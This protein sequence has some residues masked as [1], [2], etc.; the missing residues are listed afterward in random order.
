MN[1]KDLDLPVAIAHRG[2]SSLFPENTIPAFEAAI[3]MGCKMVEFDVGVTKD[4]AFAIIHDSTLE[5]TTN[6]SGKICNITSM[7]LNKLNAAD[8]FEKGGLFTKV[9]ILDDILGIFKNRVFLNIE[10][11]SEVF[12]T[13]L[14]ETSHEADLLRVVKEN[15]MIHQVLFSSFN[16]KTLLRLRRLDEN[17][18]LGILTSGYK[19]PPISMTRE[20]NA[21]SWNPDYSNLSEKSIK[22]YKKET[23]K[24]V[25]PYTINCSKKANR[26]IKAG[27][28]GFF[29]D[30][31]QKFI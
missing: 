20:L 13:G 11:K 8:K 9:P 10:V 3:N 7:E 1:I 14:D 31:P 23:G 6:G 4:R 21:F 22:H 12:K 25:I 19:R 26:L 28:D 30:C 5:R 15:K 29:T 16:Y 2:V 24:K 17:I 27:I 18:S